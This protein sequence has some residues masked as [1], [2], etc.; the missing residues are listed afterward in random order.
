MRFVKRNPISS[1]F[2]SIKISLG[3][4]TKGFWGT[5]T[6]CQTCGSGKAST[7][8]GILPQ[9]KRTLPGLQ[10][11]QFCG[12]H[13]WSLCP[14]RTPYFPSQN[15]IPRLEMPFAPS[16]TQL[17]SVNRVLLGSLC[18]VVITSM[19]KVCTP[20]LRVNIFSHDLITDSHG[21]FIHFLWLSTAATSFLSYFLGQDYPLGYTNSGSGQNNSSR[22]NLL[23]F[24]L[25]IFVTLF[26]LLDNFFS[27]FSF[28][29]TSQY[30][31]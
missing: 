29:L 26:F 27:D 13:S 7:C 3:W 12:F 30:L 15:L 11:F 5:K 20:S 2:Q 19:R 28:S 1:W 18:L 10:D 9:N 17:L 24:Y 14:T 22:N 31:R 4:F 25:K 21:R 16:S 8:V 23:E 6:P